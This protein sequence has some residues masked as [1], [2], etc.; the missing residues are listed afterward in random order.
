MV[1]GSEGK[2]CRDMETVTGGL[3]LCMCN[4]KSKRKRD[5]QARA[6]GPTANLL[7]AISKSLKFFGHQVISSIN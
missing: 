7:C 6:L 1:T 2:T 3:Q 4:S 5:R